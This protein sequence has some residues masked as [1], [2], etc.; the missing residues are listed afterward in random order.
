MGRSPT[1]L[2]IG[3]LVAFCSLA[4]ADQPTEMQSVLVP[5]GIDFIHNSLDDPQ[6]DTIRY[7]DNTSTFLNTATNFWVRVKFTAP[8]DFE[9]RSVYFRTINGSGTAAP[10]SVF[11][12]SANGDNLGTVLSSH[13][14]NGNVP[15]F[16]WVDTNVPTPVNFTAAQDFFIVIGPNPGGPQAQGWH[17]L[18]DNANTGGRSKISTTGRQG[19]YVNSGGDYWIR[20]GG[21]AAAFTDLD[22]QECFDLNR[23]GDPAFNTVLGDTLQIKAQIYNAGNTDV[24]AFTIHWSIQGPGGEVF[25]NEIA[26]STPLPSGSIGQYTAS[27]RFIPAVNGEFIATCTVN[28]TGDAVPDNDVTMLRF[29][30][31]GNHRWY[32]YDDNQTPDSYVG[33]TPG[34]GWGVTFLPA[35]TPAAIETLRFAMG[36]AGSGDFRIYMNDPTTGAP[37]GTPVW[38]AT[39][40]VVQGWNSVPVSPAVNIFE[41]E[42]FTVAYL[43]T[44]IGFGKDDTPPNDAGI[45]NMG[46]ISWQAGSDGAEWF[47]DLTGNWAIQV[48]MDTTNAL[49]PYPL[50]ETSVDTLQFGSVDTTGNTSATL[51]LWVYNQGGSQVLSVTQM[52]LNPPAIRP[53]YQLSRTTMSVAAGDS[54]FVDITFNPVNVQA[55]NGLLAMTNNSHNEPTKNIIVRGSGSPAQAVQIVESGMPTQFGLSQNFPNPFNPQTEIEFALPMSSPVTLTVFN[56]LGQEVEILASGSF[57]AGVYKV[58]FDAKNQTSGLYFYKLEAG[59]FISLKKMML[60][61]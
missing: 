11:V 23:H 7:D 41:G 53:M 51:R 48:Y 35:A 18:L 16:Q 6:P 3:I 59:S 10:C 46:I 2:L 33:F 49:P 27:Q 24:D 42:S 56:V 12:Y 55:Y 52:V 37:T 9:L 39:P 50:I 14:I 32:R 43:Y 20:A 29:F 4:L 26:V 38:S 28:A 44:T 45:T 25:T 15:D 31:G 21:Q 47:D 5:N 19:N 1:L 22:A 8:D 40:Q 36:G 58:T 30:V 13:R 60:L 17:V 57:T 61:K 34:N 54:Q